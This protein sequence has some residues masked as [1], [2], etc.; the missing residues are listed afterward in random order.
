NSDVGLA[1]TVVIGGH[2]RIACRTPR[3]GDSRT[4]RAAL[5]VPNAVACAPDSP[6][7]FSVAAIIAWDRGVG[8]GRGA[9][10]PRLLDDAVRCSARADVPDRIGAAPDSVIGLAIPV[11]ITRYDHIVVRRLASAP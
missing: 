2:G 8:I 1:I 6:V 5:G 3:L 4:I 7:G 10:A 11:I 9:R